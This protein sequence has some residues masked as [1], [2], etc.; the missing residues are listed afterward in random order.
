M[1]SP[2]R[3]NAEGDAQPQDGTSRRDFLRKNLKRSTLLP[4]VAPVIQTIYLPTDAHAQP[5]IIGNVDPN[6]PPPVLTSLTPDN[7]EI[8]V[9]P[10]RSQSDRARP[11]PSNPRSRD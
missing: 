10:S 11:A 8:G 3:E 2:D 9:R 7:G 1:S 5:S 4:Y 6:A